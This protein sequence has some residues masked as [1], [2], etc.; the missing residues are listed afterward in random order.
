ME[1]GTFFM[2][3]AVGLVALWIG[4]GIINWLRLVYA[5]QAVMQAA[6]LLDWHVRQRVGYHFS[7]EDRAKIVVEMMEIMVRRH[8]PL[9]LVINDREQFGRIMQES[10]VTLSSRHEIAELLEA[11]S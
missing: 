11:R 9:Q 1:W 10:I 5:A 3:L 2:W 7:P 6:Q 8:M 4:G